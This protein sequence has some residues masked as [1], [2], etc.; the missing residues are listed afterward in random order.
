MLCL[1][2]EDVHIHGSYDSDNARMINVQLN[3]CQG[4][5]CAD[6]ETINDFF[7]SNQIGIFANR[8]RFNPEYFGE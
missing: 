4:T 1:D 8:L 7:A 6:D 5:D 3:R 2:P